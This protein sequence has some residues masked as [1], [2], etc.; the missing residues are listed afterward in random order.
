L[1]WCLGYRWWGA[2]RCCEQGGELGSGS[3]RGSRG[4]CRRRFCPRGWAGQGVFRCW[5]G[6]AGCLDLRDRGCVQV[7]VHLVVI[8]VRF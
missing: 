1:G 2:W 5:D 4:G 8:C 3:A 6:L 7:F